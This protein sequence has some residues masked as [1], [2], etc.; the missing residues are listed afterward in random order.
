MIK[1][2]ELQVENLGTVVYCDNHAFDTAVQS[3]MTESDELSFH[4]RYGL[5]QDF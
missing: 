5:R 1:L 3:V 2:K 4:E